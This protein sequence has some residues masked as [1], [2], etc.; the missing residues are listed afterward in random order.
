MSKILSLDEKKTRLSLRE[1]FESLFRVLESGKPEFH[2]GKLKDI[3]GIKGAHMEYSFSLK[4]LGDDKFVKEFRNTHG[5]LD[6]P[7]GEIDPL[8][9]ILDEGAH[10]KVIAQ[11]PI[12]K[13]DTIKLGVEGSVLAITIDA[14]DGKY[15]KE[16]TL[17]NLVKPGFIEAA[18]KNGILEIKL[19]KAM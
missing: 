18:Y 1:I 10:M 8:I 12:V 6:K 4:T 5:H 7:L 17:P 16:V 19:K 2:A 9:D 14:P 11:L 13:E 3:G 15:H